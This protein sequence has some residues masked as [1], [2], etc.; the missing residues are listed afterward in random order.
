[1]DIIS[2]DGDDSGDIIN[3]NDSSEGSMMGL[4]VSNKLLKYLNKDEN[5]QFLTINSEEN[6]GSIVTIFLLTSGR[7][8]S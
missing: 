2:S 3:K 8:Y 4:R 1:M 6:V 5:K 7:I